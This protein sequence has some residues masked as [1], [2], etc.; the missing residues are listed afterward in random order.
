MRKTVF[1]LLFFMSQSVFSDAQNDS[2]KLF[3][4]AENQLPAYFPSSGQTSKTIDVWYY[5][6]YPNV[7]NYIAVNTDELDVYIVSYVVGGYIRV[8]TLETLMQLAGLKSEIVEAQAVIERDD[9]AYQLDLALSGSLQNPAFSPDGKSITFT[10]FIDGYNK[11]SSDIFIY[12][13]ETFELKLLVSNGDSNIN[14]PGSVWNDT[15]ESIVFSSERE[16][17]DEIYMISDTA[18]P[19]DETQLTNRN[20]KQSYEPSF[21]PDGQWVVFESHDIDVEGYGVVTKYK[22]NGESEYIELTSSTEDARQPNWS[23]AGDKILYQKKVQESWSIW[24]MDINGSNNTMITSSNESNTDAV[25]SYNGQWI[26]YSSENDDVELAN[27]YKIPSKGGDPIQ[28][29]RTDGYDGAPSISPDSTKIIFES[30]AE[31]PDKS[32]GTAIWILDI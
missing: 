11:G 17:H 10:R 3:D 19:G 16:T 22:I 4:W 5:R 21:S 30:V 13:I 25:F 29:T 28:L 31:D 6:Y 27:I 7:N 32:K 9:N 15:S 18:N 23:P 20:N 26:I 8:G 12:D 1:L 14:L 2:D 24:T